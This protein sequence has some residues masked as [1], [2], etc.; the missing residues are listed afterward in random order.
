[1]D[2]E[3][4]LSGHNLGS[5]QSPSKRKNE[6]SSS[7]ESLA[8]E[9]SVSHWIMQIRPSGPPDFAFYVLTTADGDRLR[10]SPFAIYKTIDNMVGKVKTVKRLR[11]GDLLIEVSTFQQ[12]QN[13]L[14]TKQILDQT[15]KAEPHRSLN[16]SRL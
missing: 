10:A 14:K 6:T 11:S 12:E 15:V 13:L 3:K 4:G 1:M 9:K 8:I 16:L 5:F 7:N 2:V